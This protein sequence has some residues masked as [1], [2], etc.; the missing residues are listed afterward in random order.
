[1]GCF[2]GVWGQALQRAPGTATSDYS[3]VRRCG[4]ARVAIEL[5]GTVLRLERV[6]SLLSLS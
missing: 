2:G 3:L 1:M 5:N 6:V 4:S